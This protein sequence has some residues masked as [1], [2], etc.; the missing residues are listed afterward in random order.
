MQTTTKLTDFH[1]IDMIGCV[2]LDDWMTEFEGREAASKAAA[3]ATTDDGWTVVTRKPVS[4][5][6]CIFKPSLTTS[7]LAHINFALAAH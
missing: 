7:G 3:A 1:L 6:P 4:T 2:Q 5:Q